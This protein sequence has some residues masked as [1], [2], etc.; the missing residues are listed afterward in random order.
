MLAPLSGT[1]K[2]IE[3]MPDS[4][5]S[6]KCMGDGVMI[7][8]TGTCAVAP[9]DATVSVTM[10]ASSHAVGLTLANG[11]ELL[12]HVGV[13]TVDMKGDGFTCHVS[14]GDRVKAGDVLLAFDPEKIAAA[15]H[16]AATA[17]VVS[18][19]GSAKDLQLMTGQDAV[20]G[21]TAIARCE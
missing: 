7:E 13:D 3:Q 16:P 18:A 12:I 17:V 20:V 21:E 19:M 10:P 14:Q 4:V 9:A 1:V 15:G 8:P 5:F 2:P 6:S 11:M